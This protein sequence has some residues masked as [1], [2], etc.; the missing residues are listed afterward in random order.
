MKMMNPTKAKKFQ[1]WYMSFLRELKRHIDLENIPEDI[2]Q[3]MLAVHRAL[4]ILCLS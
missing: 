1:S 3:S 2:K 4:R